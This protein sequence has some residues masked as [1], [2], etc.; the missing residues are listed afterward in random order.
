MIYEMSRIYVILRSFKTLEE[1][2]DSHYIGLPL[3][4]LFLS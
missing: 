3:N 4:N 2:K 1:I